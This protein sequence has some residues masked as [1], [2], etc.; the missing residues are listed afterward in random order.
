[1]TTASAGRTAESSLGRAG[2][3]IALARLEIH[4]YMNGTLRRAD[5]LQMTSLGGDATERI[6]KRWNDNWSTNDP[7]HLGA[8]G[9]FRTQQTVAV[10]FGTLVPKANAG[11]MTMGGLWAS[12]Y[13]EARPASSCAC[14]DEHPLDLH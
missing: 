3:A 9:I 10:A 2:N 4:E 1:M 5:S 11:R 13:Q 7:P 6:I 12:R 14:H 8:I